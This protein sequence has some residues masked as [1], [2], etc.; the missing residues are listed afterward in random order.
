MRIYAELLCIMHVNFLE[1]L[2]D[3][4]TSNGVQSTLNYKDIVHLH[5]T[6]FEW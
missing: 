5:Q 4:W 6:I 2:E 3:I 1:I